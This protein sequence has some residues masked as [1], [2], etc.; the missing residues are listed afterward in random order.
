MLDKAFIVSDDEGSVI[1]FARHGVVARREGAQ[2]LNQEFQFV[3]CRRAP[4]FDEY[5][6]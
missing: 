1:R 6:R 2:A 3:S 5:A 4:E